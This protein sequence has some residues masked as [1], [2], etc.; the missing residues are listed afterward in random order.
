MK[1]LFVYT[2]LLSIN[3]NVAQTQDLKVGLVL[4]GGAAKGI[5]HV[6]AL[7]VIEKAGVRID[8][9]GGSSM[10]AIIGALY[11]VGYSADQIEMLLEQTDLNQ[12]IADQYPRRAMS[13]AEKRDAERYILTLPFDNFQI[14]FP[15]ALSRGQ[16]VYNLLVQLLHQ[17]HEIRDFEKLPIPFYCT[18]TDI[19]TGKLVILDHGF[20]PLAVNASSALPTLFA[21]VGIGEKLYID[22]GVADNYPIEH[23]QS[24][25]MDVIIGVDVQ[26][27]LHEKSKLQSAS[28]ILLQISSFESASQSEDKKAQTDVYINPD[29]S[30]YNLLSFESKNDLIRLG[31]DTANKK[32][33][34]LLSVAK[35]QINIFKK[36][37]FK[38]IANSL[39]IQRVNIPELAHFGRNYINGKL[40]LKTPGT[41]SYK[42]FQKGLS[43]L[44]ATQNFKSFRYTLDPT[45]SGTMM[46]LEIE[47]VP[48]D[49]FLKL[50]VH[51]D[52]LYLSSALINLSWK[53]ALFKNDELSLDMIFGDN[54]RYEFDYYIDKG[55]Y[56]SIGLHS[57]LNQ[58]S[59]DIIEPHQGLPGI[60]S[61]VV[62][63][64][65]VQEN[66]VSLGTLFREAFEFE[67]GIVHQGIVQRTNLIDFDS[68]DFLYVEDSDYYSL[69]GALNL[70]TRDHLHYPTNGGHFSGNVQMYF[71]QKSSRF[72]TLSDPYYIAQA[73]MSITKSV[74]S[75]L[76]FTI[77]AAGGFTVENAQSNTFDFMFGG[78][79]NRFVLNNRPFL[80][81]AHQSISGNSF[82]MA[83]FNL[84]YNF[85]KKHHL[86]AKANFAN[87]GQDIFI[88]KA[89]LPLADYSGY[90]LGYGMDSFLGPIELTW[91][92][93]PE[94]KKRKIY[95][96]LG[97]W[98]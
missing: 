96:N 58:F 87:V 78:Y 86:T 16:D 52:D 13:F 35:Q 68:N 73:D 60:N 2:L 98:F 56:W 65:W 84:D 41:I 6:G 95:F 24:K 63:R 10:G 1:K 44:A 55:L 83:S 42:R 8:Y 71:H 88:N 18:A 70:D 3:L 90:A 37:S 5:A 79:G 34:A 89:W 51:Y 20:L 15:S 49:L 45:P 47:E 59:N 26:S 66:E 72:D 21:P 75:N 4:S 43:N 12:L 29:L 77:G 50:G 54:V 30:D 97:W 17:A 9:I 27:G 82:V 38:P 57:R 32:M 61:G 22:G 76:H 85:Y 46:N 14:Q 40:R 74:A 67:V 7:K 53:H 31:E 81:Y 28:D 25:H 80:G 11:A 93:S 62:M 48:H 92:Y 19:E 64:H 69:K 23:M 36:P 39:A 33:E 91:S 94:I